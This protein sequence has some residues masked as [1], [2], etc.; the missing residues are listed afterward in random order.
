MENI[1]NIIKRIG[2]EAETVEDM[3]Q[4]LVSE[5]KCYDTFW[6]NHRGVLSIY[7]TAKIEGE[8]A[9]I[10]DLNGEELAIHQKIVN[11]ELITNYIQYRKIKR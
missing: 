3:E 6:R 2:K 5:L 10:G 9:I 4:L 11:N 7:D 8:C 1:L